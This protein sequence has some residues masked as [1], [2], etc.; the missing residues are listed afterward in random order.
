MRTLNR[1]LTP[2]RLILYALMIAIVIA[3]LVAIDG[4]AL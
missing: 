2:T 1:H 4:T 3:M